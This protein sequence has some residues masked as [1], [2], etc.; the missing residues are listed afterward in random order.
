MPASTPRPSIDTDLESRYA[1]QR[2]GGA[3]DA[4]EAGTLG[5]GDMG[6]QERIWTKQGFQTAAGENLGMGPGG[7]G[8]TKSYDKSLMRQGFNNRKYKP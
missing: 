5:L 3:F 6:I 2:A 4:K 1:T 8:G 7:G